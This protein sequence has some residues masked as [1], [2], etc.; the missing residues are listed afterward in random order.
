MA[1]IL[2]SAV[3]ILICL[4]P[5]GVR[6]ISAQQ[7]NPAD[8]PWEGTAKVE[9]A[10]G[11]TKEVGKEKLN[12][13]QSAQSEAEARNIAYEK[14]LRIL[15]SDPDLQGSK[16]VEGS[17]TI[18]LGEP[19]PIGGGGSG[20]VILALS[21]YTKKFLREENDVTVLNLEVKHRVEADTFD[22]EAT[23]SVGGDKRTF[24]GKLK[25]WE[26]GDPSGWFLSFPVWR[27]R[28]LASEGG[29]AINIKI[30]QNCTDRRE[31]TGE[32]KIHRDDIGE[33]S[34][35][36]RNVGGRLEANCEPIAFANVEASERQ[37]PLSWSRVNLSGGGASYDAIVNVIDDSSLK[38]SGGRVGLLVNKRSSKPLEIRPS[39]YNKMLHDNPP[40]WWSRGD[41]AS[42]QQ[43]P[44]RARGFVCQEW[45]MLP[46]KVGG[47]TLYRFHSLASMKSLGIEGSQTGKDGARANQWDYKLLDNHKPLYFRKVPVEGN[48]FK[49]VNLESGKL[50]EFE[51]N[52]INDVSG[53]CPA[54]QFGAG[55]DEGHRTWRIDDL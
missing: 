31:V 2:I 45:L 23:V 35:I 50:L 5:S 33:F 20:R 48:W 18:K 27:G 7:V 8:W 1:R 10:P 16:L 37:G 12:G 44:G 21:C 14:A 32:V 24:Q 6:G 43:G 25:T 28:A 3:T 30:R 19:L 13:V 47:E 53:N 51:L 15:R 9:V 54:Q 17:L 36:L 52:R 40:Y 42:A 41:N 4:D 34:I 29:K 38:L 55:G 46:V 11:F 26:T 39:E 49:L 22:V